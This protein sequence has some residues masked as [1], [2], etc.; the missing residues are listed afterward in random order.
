MKTATDK[1]TFQFIESLAKGAPPATPKKYADGGGL[2][3][4]HTPTGAR[5]WRLK[6]RIGGAEQLLTFGPF[7]DVP[8]AAARKLRDAAR[9]MIAAGLDPRD[10]KRAEAD[11]ASLA[12]ANTFRVFAEALLADLKPRQAPR[13]VA[14][15]ELHLGYAIAEFGER[16]IGDL[17]LGEIETFLDG[18]QKAGKLHTLHSVKRKIADVL[19]KARRAGATELRITDDLKGVF[20]PALDV[21]H[22]AITD[23]VR[24]GEMLR[25]IDGLRGDP[26]TRSALQFL[27]L[28]FQRPGMIRA[29]EWSEINFE[30]SLWE[31]PAAKMKGQKRDKRDHVVALSRQA[32]AVLAFMRPIS[33]VPDRDGAPLGLVFPGRTG[34]SA[35]MS[36]AT[37][38]MALRRLKFGEEH[39]GHGFRATANTMLKEHLGYRLDQELI[40]LAL[41]H[42]I[43]G[44]LGTAY[45]RVQFLDRRRVLMQDWADFLDRVRHPAKV[46]RLAA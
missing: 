36:D 13:T 44:P 32:L 30:A 31:I 17:K 20:L 38:N 41:A 40:D 21:N 10:I 22:P 15:W 28:T 18:F 16:P 14:K 45:N 2:F 9:A 11:A 4:L 29:M 7:D 25:A 26:S 1:L 5:V 34:R 12:K 8:L 46:T 3:L 42:A 39:V 27:A 37:L 24:L 33:G 43:K 35:P 6:Y 19:R 23:P